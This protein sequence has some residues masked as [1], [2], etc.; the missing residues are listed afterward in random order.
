MPKTLFDRLQKKRVRI[1]PQDLEVLE[2]GTSHKASEAQVRLLAAKYKAK[3]KVP[4]TDGSGETTIYE[5]G[6]GQVAKRHREKA[7]RAQKLRDRL[8]ELRRTV[9][10]DLG[11]PDPK[12]RLTALAVALI[13]ETYERVGN[14]KSAEAGHHGVT[15]WTVGHV[16]LG[17][18]KATVQYTGKSGVKQEKV[19]SSAATL[20]GLKQALKGKPKSE[21]LL[22]EGSDCTVLSKDVNA[23]LKPFDVTAKDIRGLHANEEMLKELRRHRK[24]GPTLPRSR[25]EKDKILK[26]EFKSALAQAAE[27]VGH[28]GATLKGQY[29]VP[30][31]EKSYLHDG[32]VL[33]NLKKAT[34]SDSEKEDREADRLVRQSPKKKPPRVDLER[35]RVKDTDA[36]E[37]DPDDKA[38]KK[39]LSNNYKDASAVAVAARF[40]AQAKTSRDV[41]KKDTVTVKRKDT[42]KVV[43]VTEDTLKE[44]GGEFEEIDEEEPELD[45][46]EGDEPP[47]GSEKTE[48]KTDAQKKFEKDYNALPE[49]DPDAEV[50][51]DLEDYVDTRGVAGG[52]EASLGAY[53][54]SLM[55]KY[56]AHG[57]DADTMA[58]ALSGVGEGSSKNDLWGVED[59]LKAALEP[60]TEN[61]TSLKVLKRELAEKYTLDD[62]SLNDILKGLVVGSDS[63][64]I[65]EVERALK[66]ASKK[67]KKKLQREVEGI[68]A[69][70]AGIERKKLLEATADYS[71]EQVVD[72]VEGR[73]N[74]LE[75]LMKQDL[76]KDKV[77]KKFVEDAREALTETYG[78]AGDKLRK[79]PKELARAL[80][81]IEHYDKVVDNPMLS[82]TTPIAEQGA[83]AV[84]KKGELKGLFDE[85]V[86]KYRK[87]D[88]ESLD[89]HLDTMNRQLSAHEKGSLAHQ[90][91]SAAIKGAT[92]SKIVAEG[93]DAQAGG[94][95]SALMRAADNTGYLSELSGFS[96][97]DSASGIT[98]DDQALVRKIYSTLPDEEWPKLLPEDHPG[99]SLADA[100]ND[101]A[102][103]G[104]FLDEADRAKYRE[105]LVDMSIAELAF[106]DPATKATGKGKATVKERE[107]VAGPLRAKSVK[108]PTKGKKAI[109]SWFDKFMESISKITKSNPRLSSEHPVL[110]RVG[111]RT[112][113]TNLE[114]QWDFAPW[115]QT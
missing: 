22:C 77:F 45:P 18:K 78:T 110:C 61:A 20:K 51:D 4:K 14:E 7:E 30:G 64:D 41:K 72:L 69:E 42:G 108:A 46:E 48:K 23:Y 60:G 40:S 95:L 27:A 70:V 29:L 91:I 68:T 76:S 44:R 73:N 37:K 84:P 35:G 111:S 90:Q 67:F 21:R 26:A 113:P 58:E 57:V 38:D 96:A 2:E 88:S 92:V 101:P 74:E 93:S 15:N 39:D 17:P 98:T 24:A 52:D 63:D 102:G 54:K 62:A 32:T 9:R 115:P 16:T 53:R 79:N 114:T 50:P 19:V 5:Y 65:K 11:S 43:K 34:L 66:P 112:P 80:A 36:D 8:P 12:T 105:M 31:L 104:R 109:K 75:S 87:M 10:R 3:R 106:I 1:T 100:L 47:A 83:S 82:F 6:P 89:R 49:P 71:V 99:R 103:A 97:F 25:K 81:S 107:A 28:E 56:R 94:G 85:A 13:D 55:Q 33:S 59:A 86:D